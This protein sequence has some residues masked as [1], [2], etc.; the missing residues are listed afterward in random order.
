M[1]SAAEIAQAAYE[2]A[3]EAAKAE[4]LDAIRAEAEARRIVETRADEVFKEGVKVLDRWFPGVEWSIRDMHS[5][6]GS[7]MGYGHGEAVVVREASSSAPCFYLMIER[8]RSQIRIYMVESK[9][10]RD[11]SYGYWDGPE[12][13]SAA[14]VGRI[15]LQRK[16]RA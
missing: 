13:K 4:K 3:I 2:Q 14:D 11:T 5:G 12:V 10:D 7:A 9:T 15:L 6:R 16:A 1:S 8:L